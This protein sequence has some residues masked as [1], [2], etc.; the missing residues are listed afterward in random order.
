MSNFERKFGKYAIP[1]LTVILIGCYVI[2][3]LM[4]LINASFLDFLTLDAYKILIE[5]Q[6]WR[7]FTWII[8]P[9]D[10]LNIFTLIML[11]FYYSIGTTM[12]RTLGTYKYNVFLFRGMLLTTLASVLC[13][14]ICY[15]FPNVTLSL[16]GETYRPLVTQWLNEDQ[17]YVLKILY[18]ELAYV[19]STYYINI[20]I[21]LAFAIV[22]PEMQVYLMFVIPVKVKWLGI[23]DLVVMLYSFVVG[24]IFTRFSVGAALINIAIFY[25]SVRNLGYLKPNR[26]VRRAQFV[27]K[28]QT[29]QT[30]TKH[31]CAI[32]GQTEKDNPELEFRFCSKCKGNYEYCSEHLYTHEHIK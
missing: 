7:I 2:G 30:Y 8:V 3:Y 27:K 32:C 14:G 18:S 1:N 13:F 9:P 16:F 26:I 25:T 12:E 15:F 28:V 11:I 17:L 19:F 29:A 4:Q 10:D 20:S 31:K 23:L 21:F 24:N 22:Y 6:V 5:V